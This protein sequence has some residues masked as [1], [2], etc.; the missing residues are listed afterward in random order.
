MDQNNTTKITSINKYAGMS[1][2]EVINQ[3][4][5]G[6]NGIPTTKSVKPSPED[7][8]AAMTEDEPGSVNAQAGKILAEMRETQVALTPE[9]SAALDNNVLK[10]PV[11][12]V[13]PIQ[14]FPTKNTDHLIKVNTLFTE[15][16]IK[17]TTTHINGNAVNIRL[18]GEYDGL[19]KAIGMATALIMDS[20]D[21]YIFAP[22]QRIISDLVFL[23]E[24]SNLNL[25]FLTLSEIR[26]S[27]MIETY[28]LVMPVLRFVEGITEDEFLYYRGWYYQELQKSIDSALSYQNSAKGIVDAIARHNIKDQQ[29]MTEQLTTLESDKLSMVM[30]FIK[31]VEPNLPK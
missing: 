29:T 17:N 10:L 9:E 13:I 8:I 31:K 11:T 25:E 5:G 6:Q 1:A 21:D 20:G 7:V 28:D 24:V 23:R 22:N 16:P 3:A 15:Q 19:V 12:P 30:D 26:F 27:Q 2:D 14:A 18:N 4:L